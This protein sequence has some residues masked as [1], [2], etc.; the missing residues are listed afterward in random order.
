MLQKRDTVTQV[1]RESH[2]NSTET[3]YEVVKLDG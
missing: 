1:N 2:T 3:K